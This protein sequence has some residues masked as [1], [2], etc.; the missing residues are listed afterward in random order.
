MDLI[1]FSRIWFINQFEVSWYRPII[2]NLYHQIIKKLLVKC[3]WWIWHRENSTV[4]LYLIFRAY[5][6]IL[7]SSCRTSSTFWNCRWS[8]RTRR[9]FNLTTF[10]FR[11]HHRI[12]NIS[13]DII[14]KILL[15]QYSLWIIFVVL[16]DILFGSSIYVFYKFFNLFHFILITFIY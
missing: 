16:N 6:H 12:W 4:N 5:F 11:G 13:S 15:K 10:A 14:S 3:F 7:C 9:I 1:T 2:V 8:I